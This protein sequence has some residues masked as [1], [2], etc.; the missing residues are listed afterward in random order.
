MLDNITY[1]RKCPYSDPNKPLAGYKIFTAGRLSKTKAQLKDIIKNMGGDFVT[2]LNSKTTICISNNSELEL[3]S[4]AMKEC[5]ELGVPVL[6]LEFLEDVSTNGSASSKISP[7]TIS[8]WTIDSP[9][10]AKRLKGKEETDFGLMEKGI[11]REKRV[12][13][14]LGYVLVPMKM[15]MKVKGGAVVDPDSGK[16]TLMCG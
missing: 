10:P 15:K 2:S 6:D 12:L 1:A 11:I 7:H 14:I 5:K 9:R 8:S 13:I 3:D 16:C 4:K